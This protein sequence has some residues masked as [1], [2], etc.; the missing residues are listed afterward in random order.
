MS[1]IIGEIYVLYNNN[2]ITEKGYTPQMRNNILGA[3]RQIMGQG[4]E[5]MI[6]FDKNG[7]ELQRINGKGRNAYA[8]DNMVSL[9]DKIITHNH[10]PSNYRLMSQSFSDADIKTAVTENAKEI[11]ITSPSFTYSLKR[12]SKGWVSLNEARD[13]ERMQLYGREFAIDRK[14][15]GLIKQAYENAGISS[16]RKDERRDF[17]TN[18]K[19]M[20]ELSK[21]T[22]WS[23]TRRRTK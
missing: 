10:P 20:K 17:I 18:H 8:K 15:N 22:G 11:R 13:K 3:E 2:S 9:K 14:V 12:P 21:L 7:N 19:V 16:Y 23:Y 5:T 1:R 6:I 4:Y